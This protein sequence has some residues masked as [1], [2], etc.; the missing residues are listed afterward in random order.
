M[1]VYAAVGRVA[2]RRL[3]FQELI[4]SA[5]AGHDHSWVEGVQVEESRC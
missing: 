5:L 4:N 1:M 3:D 2:H